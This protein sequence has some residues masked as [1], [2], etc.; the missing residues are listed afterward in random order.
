MGIFTEEDKLMSMQEAMSLVK[1][2]QMVA[3]GGGL[4]LR[5]PIAA[6]C[7]LIR[8]KKRKL[9]IVGTAH[10]FD[11]DLTCGG[12]IVGIEQHTYV[13]Y[14]FVYRGGCP[15]YRRVV[16][17]GLVEEKE[18]G[19]YAVIQGLRAGAYGI[20]FYPSTCYFGTD[21]IK[22]H[23]DYKEFKD[24]ISGRRLVAIPPIKPDVTI[25]HCYKAD[26]HGN[27]TVGAPLVADILM[28]RAA[29]KVIITAEE[30][31]EESWFKERQAATI[32]YYETTAVVHAPYGA[33]PTAC[34]LYYTYDKDFL[35]EYISYMG[36]GPEGVDAWFNKYV[37]ECGTHE[38][39]LKRV[40]EQRLQKIKNWRAK[41]EAANKLKEQLR[42]E[43]VV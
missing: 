41:L 23:P 14:E 18:D 31:V 22:F 39:Y 20:P 21:V 12:G 9:H 15:N 4:I 38:E 26:K 8:Q 33:H 32:P 3:I 27:A 5:E 24:P 34:Y 19:C 30:I 2:G 35:N 11:V 7:E 25:L 28:A 6:L 43:V 42:A 40:G 10:G 29:N 17:Q 16:E 1:D 13:G 36:K 37:Y